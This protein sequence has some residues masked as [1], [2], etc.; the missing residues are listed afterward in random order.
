[1]RYAEQLGYADEANITANSAETLQT[2]L[3]R[4]A[5]SGH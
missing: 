4:I 3:T 1:M 2:M 5:M